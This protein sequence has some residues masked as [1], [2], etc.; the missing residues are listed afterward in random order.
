MTPDFDFN[1]DGKVDMQ[2]VHL[3]E[4]IF[5]EESKNNAPSGSSTERTY[6]RESH[7]RGVSVGSISR[8]ISARLGRSKFVYACSRH[9]QLF[10]ADSVLVF[11]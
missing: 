8:S 4:D 10:C 1:H 2:D 11:R 3:Y 6:E 9:S 5:S 7:Y